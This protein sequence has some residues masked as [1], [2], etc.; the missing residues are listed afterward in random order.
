MREGRESFRVTLPTEDP[1]HLAMT[2]TRI[3]GAAVAVFATCVVVGSAAAAVMAPFIAERLGPHLRDP[4]AQGLLLPALL[5][6][7][8]LIAACLVVL[9]RMLRPQTW[10]RGLGLGAVLGLAV[11]EGDHLVTAGWSTLDAGV[12]AAS[13][14]VD[15]VAVMAGALVCHAVLRQPPR[16][17]A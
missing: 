9:Y 10:A 4:E 13:G 5:G 12:M 16:V 14:L 2:Q 8:G 7:Y 17:A 1:S 11:F 3:L 6:G 15:A